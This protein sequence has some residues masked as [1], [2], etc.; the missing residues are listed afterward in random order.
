ML[1]FTGAKNEKEARPEI[2]K[3]LAKLLSFSYFMIRFV[4]ADY[5]SSPNTAM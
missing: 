5:L 1:A 3:I 2:R 4:F